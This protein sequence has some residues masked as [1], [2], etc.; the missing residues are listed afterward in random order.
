MTSASDQRVTATATTT[1]DTADR[2]VLF[3]G[4]ANPVLAAA[5]AGALGTRLGACHVERF[6]DGETSVRLDASVRGREVFIVQPTAPPVNDNLIE[7]LA[8]ADACRRASAERITA[9]VPYFGY[10]RSD[11]RNRRRE[12]IMASLAAELMQC[13]GIDHVVLVDVHTPQVEGFFRVPVDSLTAVPVLCGSI[14][15]QLP[16]EVTSDLVVVSPDAGR[17][18][19]ATEYARRLGAPLAVLHKRRDGG[20]E[21]TMM[22][23]VG[24]V[25]DR[26]CLV[27]DDMIS[28]GSTIV[29]SVRALRNA[30]ALPD[31]SVVATH[32]LLV[33]EA[34]DRMA[35]TGVRRIFVTDS[36]A[37]TE[38]RCAPAQLPKLDVHVASIAPLLASAIRH[39]LADESLSDLF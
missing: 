7:L 21:V 38:K 23:L 25:R 27:A 35:A 3:A 8:F 15:E 2:F 1:I 9:I 18:P 26:P 32:G 20:D 24:D 14:R 37:D 16:S 19:M 4:T 6:P 39:H 30:G 12:P 33:D 5:V 29:E 28:T 13:S 11:R 34:C 36:V 22:H 10:S 17:V 31:I